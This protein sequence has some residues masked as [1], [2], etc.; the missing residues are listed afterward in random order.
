MDF[1]TH[2]KKRKDRTYPYPDNSFILNQIPFESHLVVSGFHV[3][4]CVDKF[5]RYAYEKGLN[6]LVD[7]DLT[8]FL[9]GRIL[10]LLGRDFNLT[11][12]PSINPKEIKGIPFELFM[13][14]REGKPRFFQD[15]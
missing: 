13:R 8:E 1:E 15:Y 5:A 9:A 7:E 4:D 14:A 3:W 12:Y 2:I 6:V 11:T 10:G